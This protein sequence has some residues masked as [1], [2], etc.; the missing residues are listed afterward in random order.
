[1]RFSLPVLF[2]LTALLAAAAPASAQEVTYGG[3]RLP[4]VKPPRTY[5]PSMG[6]TIRTTPG[7]ATV[8]FETTLA[9]GRTTEDVSGRKTVAFDG[10]SF[11]AS[12]AS[13]VTSG[14]V[15]VEYAWT[16]QGTADGSKAAGTVHIAG[17]RRV[18]RHGRWKACTKRPDR[19]FSARIDAPPSGPAA[20]GGGLYYGLSDV[21]LIAGLRAPVVLHA[22]SDGSRVAARWT[23]IAPCNRGPSE[24]FTNFTP[25]TAVRS[26]HTFARSEKF[27]QRFADAVVRYRVRFAGSFTTDGASGTLRLRTTVYDRRGKRV[28]ARCDSGTRAWHALRAQ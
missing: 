17:R 19:A 4:Y 11:D 27:A 6:V 5:I 23:T 9:C 22:T 20:G 7:Q 13:I 2:A 25:S 8:R 24:H 18:R 21:V 16:L 26:D 15:R 3:G 12:G 14:R 10:A 28:R 1:M